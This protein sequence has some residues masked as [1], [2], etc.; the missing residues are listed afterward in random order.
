MHPAGPRQRRRRIVALQR[1]LEILLLESL[2]VSPAWQDALATLD[3]P[4][5]DIEAL[6]EQLLTD[7]RATQQPN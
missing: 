4:N 7:W 3:Q 5:C 2:S 6:A 1:A